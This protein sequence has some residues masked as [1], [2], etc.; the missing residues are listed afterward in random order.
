MRLKAR[1]L[2]AA[3]VLGALLAAPS[4][5][6]ASVNPA[7]IQKPLA[8]RVRHELAMLPYYNVFDNLSFTLDG[9]RVTLLGEVVRPVLKSDAEA[10]VRR[11]PGV[12]SVTNEVKVLPLSPMD[13]G[14]RLR[15][16]YTLYRDSVL[17]RYALGAVPSIHIIV[18]RGQVTLEGVVANEADRNIANIRANSVPG[19]FSVTNN[20]RVERS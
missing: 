1:M 6:A 8:E 9:G 2:R 4:F 3:V 19:V 16:Y 12:E 20:L 18:D 17:S 15:E 10:A 13:D 7:A 14:I 5:L 11:I